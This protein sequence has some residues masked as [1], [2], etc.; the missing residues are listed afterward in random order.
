MDEKFDVIIVGGGPAGAAAALYL[1]DHGLETVVVERGNYSGAKN[2]TGGRIYAHSLK[3]LIPSINDCPFERKVVKERISLMTEKSAST[4]EY[5]SDRL[6]AGEVESFTVL[7]GEFD[8]WLMGKAEEAGAMPVTGVRVDDLVFKDGKVAGIIAGGEE[9]L[10]DAVILADGANSLLTDKAG[11]RKEKIS[12]HQM[13]VGA[14]EVIELDE[15]TVADRFGLNDGEGAA[16]LFAG[17][18]SA[19]KIGG[20]FIYTNKS[21]LS[22]GIV[23]TLSEIEKSSKSVHEMLEDFKAHPVVAPLIKGGKLGEYSGHIVPEGGLDMMPSLY[24]NGVLVAGD[25]AGLVINVGYTVRGMDLAIAS[26]LSAAEAIIYAKTKGDF[27]S[28]NLSKY[29]E[30]LEDSFV[31]KEMRHFRKFPHFMENSRIFND[32]PEMAD[33]MLAGIFTVDG[34]APKSMFSKIMRPAK[35]VGLINIAKDAIK[36]VRAL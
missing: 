7:R 12:P 11:L 16:W 22:L 1:A 18:P 31:M 10:A 21:S 4:M 20:G 2:M 35:K 29:Q 23:V 28:A 34:S 25:A 14:K 24:G 26:G 17:Y 32:Y 9:M 15:K 6:Y 33:E 30:L 5:A 19:G 27:S 3:R 13:A 36:G 8:R